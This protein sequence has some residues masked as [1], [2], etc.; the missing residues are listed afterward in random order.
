MAQQKLTA[1]EAQER[2]LAGEPIGEVL[3]VTDTQVKA[4]MA[5]GYNQYQQG[6]LKDAETIFRGVT[7]LDGKS[8]MGWAG[9]GAVALARKPPD[10]TTAFDSLTKAAEL[11][12]D[13]GTIQA[14]LGEVLLRQGKVEEAKTHLEKAFQSDPNHKDP[15]VNRARAIVSGLNTIVQEVEKRLQAE[16]PQAKAS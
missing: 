9:L 6:K 3:G 12:P 2:I 7:S 14:N 11:K 5:I 16:A 8:Y 1:A 13:D 4:I 15:G 10:L